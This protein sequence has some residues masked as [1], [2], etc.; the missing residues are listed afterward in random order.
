MAYLDALC[1]SNL[2]AV[3]AR[4]REKAAKKRALP[5][6]TAPVARTVIHVPPP[7]PPTRAE[8]RAAVLALRAEL[9]APPPAA[10]PPAAGAFA[11]PVMVRP[12]FT[13]GVLVKF[14]IGGIWY[15]ARI[16]A[17][18]VEGNEVRIPSSALTRLPD[19]AAA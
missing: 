5:V 6:P 1:A 3:A 16:P 15:H 2:E 11:V 17:D 14:S 8:R 7:P 12:D 13:P 19:S 18:A 9:A 4:R 10:P